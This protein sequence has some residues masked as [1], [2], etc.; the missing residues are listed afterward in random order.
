MRIISVVAAY[1]TAAVVII[2]VIDD[3]VDYVR[4]TSHRRPV[5]T[6]TSDVTGGVSGVSR[7][8]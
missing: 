7:S 1:T 5:T 6:A 8:E 2:V 3:V 4:D